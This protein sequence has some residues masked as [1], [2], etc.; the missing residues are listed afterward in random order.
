MSDL[1]ELERR[2]EE[3]LAAVE[4]RRRVQDDT[5]RRSIVEFQQRHEHYT[6]VADRMLQTII[7]PRMQKVAEYFKH[8]RIQG[9]DATRTNRCVLHL[10]PTVRFPT[11][12]MF[13]F[14]VSRDA[15]CETLIVLSNLE[16]LP[17]FFAFEGREQLTLPLGR[18][19][20]DAVAAWAD[21]RL[22]S[23]VCTY[24]RV[25]AADQYDVKH[26]ATDPVCGMRINRLYATA[27]SEFDGQTYYFCL[28]DCQ[29]K[30][31]KDP[32]QYLVGVDL[33]ITSRTAS[34]AS[35]P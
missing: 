14:T 3:E 13:E 19:N 20:D 31:V 4:E 7:R 2:V 17:V 32:R 23:F 16:I 8:A 24:L 35:G 9:D 5:Q 34:I 1:Q 33:P 11:R 26:F 28:E 6:A 27:Q 15:Q 22:V 25:E 30:F 29:R 12:A 10:D 21:E 18:V